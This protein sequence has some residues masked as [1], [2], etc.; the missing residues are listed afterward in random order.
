MAPP[1]QNPNPPR[2]LSPPFVISIDAW[3]EAPKGNIDAHA[4][5][6]GVLE[7]F[8]LTQ[9]LVSNTLPGTL[10]DDGKSLRL[11]NNAGTGSLID[12]ARNIR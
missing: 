6:R 8:G 12:T 5:L 4:R 3:Q 9:G 7:D 10:I 11:S 2:I 1:L